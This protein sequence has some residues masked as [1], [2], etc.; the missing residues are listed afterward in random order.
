MSWIEPGIF[1]CEGD[2]RDNKTSLN[3]NVKSKPGLVPGLHFWPAE[4]VICE[5]SEL[6]RRHPPPPSLRQHYIRTPKYFARVTVKHNLQKFA[7]NAYGAWGTPTGLSRVRS[8]TNKLMNSLYP[9]KLN[10]GSRVRRDV[11][12]ACRPKQCALSPRYRDMSISAAPQRAWSRSTHAG[13]EPTDCM[14]LRDITR[15]RLVPPC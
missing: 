8:L 10:H 9:L 1:W 15:I 5:K 6:Q 7:K 13:D 2:A 14:S 4:I 11:V 12:T 3:V